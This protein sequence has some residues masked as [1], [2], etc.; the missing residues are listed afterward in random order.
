MG[1]RRAVSTWPSCKCSFYDY[2]NDIA[3]LVRFGS[4]HN[5]A[6]AAELLEKIVERY[7]KYDEKV[8]GREGR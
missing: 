3:N 7:K 4:Q 2:Q 6:V 5:Q 1:N 8:I